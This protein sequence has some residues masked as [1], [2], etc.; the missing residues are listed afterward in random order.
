[1]EDNRDILLEIDHL[2][3]GYRKGDPILNGINLTLSRGETLC[4]VG[5][6]GCGKSTLAKAIMGL[7]PFRQGDI[8]FKGESIMGIPTSQLQSKG[9]SIMFQGG[10]VFTNLSGSENLRIAIKD[11]DPRLL[12]VLGFIPFLEFEERVK[13][14]IADKYSGGERCQLSLFMTLMAGRDLVILDEPSAGLMPSA[15]DELYALLNKVRERFDTSF[16]LI[17]QNVRRAEEFADR[18]AFMDNGSISY[19]G[20]DKETIEKLMFI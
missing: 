3:A 8:R 10:R 20:G 1:M 2:V 9:I 5:R 17:E 4:V 14:R 18:M 16:L 19:V 6:N 15:V 13:D 12:K 7:T 11:Q